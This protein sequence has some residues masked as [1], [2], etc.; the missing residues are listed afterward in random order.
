[1]SAPAAELDA[2][3]E[4]GREVAPD[5]LAEA[6]RLWALT[7]TLAVTDWRLRF[8]GSVLGVLW[9]LVRPFAFFG[10]ILFVFTE[11]AGLDK[12]V[13]NYAI[14][15]LFALVLFTFF[16]EVTSNSV[17]SLVARESLLRKMRFHPIVIPLSVAVTALLNLAMTFV[18]VL[19]FSVIFGVWPTWRWVELPLL[20]AAMTALAL[21]VGML[22]SALYVRYRDVQPIWDVALQMLFYASSVLY[23]AFPTVPDEYRDYFLC[24]PIAALFAQMRRMVVDPHAPSVFFLMGWRVAI[25]GAIIVGLFALGLWFF[26]R[27][28]PR[29]AENL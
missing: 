10:V 26:V 19:V 5:R 2:A 21:G 23:V 15:I 9:T 28:S 16:S 17:G 27:E 29:V 8:Y 25:P 24:N 18:A 1:M 20:I 4:G 11:I 14:Y 3:A 6:R 13:H 22:L 12:D 7:W